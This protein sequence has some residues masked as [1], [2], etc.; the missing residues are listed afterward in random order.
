MRDIDGGGAALRAIAV[1]AIALAGLVAA[2]SPLGARLDD[3]LLDAQWRTLRA[4]APRPCADEIVIVGVDPATVA[5]IP[6]PPALWH[7]SL[8]LALARI[9]AAHPRAIGLELPLPDRSYEALRPGLDRAFLTG[10]AAAAQ[11]GPLVTALAID[12]RTRSARQVYPP[13]LALLGSDRLAIGLIAR[14]A[15]GTTRRFSLLVPTDDGGYPSFAGRLCRALGGACSDGLVD[16]ALGPKFRYVPLRNVIEAP[17]M[18]TLGKIFRGRIVLIGETQPYGSRIAVPV[19][20]AGWEP[21]RAD[22][23]AIVVHA[24][25]LR[26]ALAGAPVDAARPWSVLLAAAAALVFLVRRSSLA[27]A[28]A[29]LAAILLVAGALAAL[30]AGVHVQVAGAL[31]TLALAGG[32]RLAANLRNIPHRA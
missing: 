22:S 2:L 6:E 5:S 13:Y 32:A 11:N 19:N 24:Q 25:S 29:L 7:A 8:G 16:F 28:T 26:T 14:D 10:L 31:F 15:D 9:A 12:A 21:E 27:M 17:D 30:H 18:Q 1:A 3:A 20:L 4:F 23:P